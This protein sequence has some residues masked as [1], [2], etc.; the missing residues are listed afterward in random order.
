MFNFDSTVCSLLETNRNYLIV[1]I[2]AYLTAESEANLPFTSANKDTKYVAKQLQPKR[3][4]WRKNFQ[5]QIQ[6]S[7]LFLSNTFF[8][9]QMHKGQSPIIFAIA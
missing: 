4:I 1:M 7:K 9:Y 6:I 2:F 5:K 8:N 3:K